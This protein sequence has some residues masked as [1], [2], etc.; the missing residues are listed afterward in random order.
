MVGYEH[1]GL[2]ERLRRLHDRDLISG[3]RKEVGIIRANANQK[4]RDDI[5]IG[6]GHETGVWDCERSQMIPDCFTK[7]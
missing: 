7:G 3:G 5:R 4:E 6:G 2:W 1:H